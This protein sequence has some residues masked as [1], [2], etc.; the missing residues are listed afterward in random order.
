[1]RFLK[2]LPLLWFLSTTSLYGQQV[3]PIRHV[4]TG[5]LNKL[6][7]ISPDNKVLK[8]MDLSKHSPYNTLR[9]P[10]VRQNTDTRYNV[11]NLDRGSVLNTFFLRP[12][13]RTQ[14]LSFKP[15][16]LLAQTNAVVD[17]AFV[18]VS[19]QLTMFDEDG[20]ILGIKS[21]AK[22]YNNEGKLLA[23]LPENNDGYFE[24]SVAGSGKFLGTLFG[25]VAADAEQTLLPPPGFRLYDLQSGRIIY[26][27]RSPNEYSVYP[28][29][30]RNNLII[31]TLGYPND[32]HEYLVFDTS[33]RTLYRKFFST[34]EVGQLRKITD[35]AFI[36]SD[37]KN[38]RVVNYQSEF[39]KSSF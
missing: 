23:A 11:K 25:D 17:K 37:G 24:M 22:V 18:V 7:F 15:S 28:T 21:Q 13:D 12:E 39:N 10:A 32:R 16:A 29:M 1:M 20:G 38:E 2:C 19:D 5:A 33:N 14:S 31:E 27:L 34:T 6:E 8:T 35:T 3:P 36:F 26:E 30:S 9:Y 4:Q